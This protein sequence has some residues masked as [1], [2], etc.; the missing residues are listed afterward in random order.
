VVA[1][2]GHWVDHG[3]ARHSH[4][5]PNKPISFLFYLFS[6]FYVLELNIVLVFDCIIKVFVNSAKFYLLK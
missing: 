2:F 4:R 5:G 3:P 1:D 6:K